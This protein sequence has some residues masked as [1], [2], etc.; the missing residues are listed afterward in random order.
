MS[1]VF[2]GD[3]GTEIVL[4]CG[5]DVSTATVRN[6]IVRKHNGTKVTWGAVADGTTAIKYVTSAG[7]LD[8]PGTWKLQA[9]VEM[10]G[11][12]GLGEVATLTVSNPL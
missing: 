1:T 5:I 3:T 9:Y 4:D 7:D 10:P 2:I 11:W 12:K 6:I 8:V